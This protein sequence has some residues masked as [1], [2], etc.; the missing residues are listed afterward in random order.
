MSTN[1]SYISNEGFIRL[2]KVYSLLNKEGLISKSNLKSINNENFATFFGITEE[3]NYPLWG[4]CL[5]KRNIMDGFDQLNRKKDI[6]LQDV[7]E[8]CHLEN[9]KGDFNAIFKDCAREIEQ[10]LNKRNHWYLKIS[11]DRL[12]FLDKLFLIIETLSD[13]KDDEEKV[14][15]FSKLVK[16]L[17]D[18]QAYGIWSGHDW[19]QTSINHVLKKVCDD[20]SLATVSLV[21][22]LKTQMSSINLENLN[23][24]LL[25]LIGTFKSV[26]NNSIL[27]K[28]N[29]GNLLCG[30]IENLR[31][32]RK[33]FNIIRLFKRVVEERNKKVIFFRLELRNY[34]D[35]NVESIYFDTE[36][37]PIKNVKDSQVILDEQNKYIDYISALVVNYFK[38]LMWFLN[39]AQ[40]LK[41]IS[42]YAFDKAIQG[43]VNNDFIEENLVRKK[44][45]S[46]LQLK[47]PKISMNPFGSC[48]SLDS[49][50]DDSKS[51][52]K[53]SSLSL[54]PSLSS[55]SSNKSLSVRLLQIEA[56]SSP[57]P[58][59]PPKTK[60][61][62]KSESC[63]KKF[64][65]L[66]ESFNKDCHEKEQM[67]EVKLENTSITKAVANPKLEEINEELCT[68]AICYS[69]FYNNEFN[70]DFKNELEKVNLEKIEDFSHW[71]KDLSYFKNITLNQSIYIGNQNKTDINILNTSIKD[72]LKEI[73]LFKESLKKTN[74]KAIARFHF[75]PL[76][77][78]SEN[79]IL[80]FS[81]TKNCYR[82]MNDEGA[83]KYIWN[84]LC[85]SV[86][87]KADIKEMIYKL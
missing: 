32:N 84:A 40:Y 33:N 26:L 7:I 47:S 48:E 2:E 66:K 52:L 57:E 43:K 38:S 34:H 85:D 77:D 23:E 74:S 54:S 63:L 86:A 67:N 19:G 4:F 56:N 29:K 83:I 18:I 81:W 5:Y 15:L 20:L 45:N 12:L 71:S 30:K 61:T 16:A 65:N 36:L 11:K 21:V 50:Q 46:L 79:K 41:N 8:K 14:I 6:L 1:L 58:K 62:K 82:E 27:P 87:L 37:I 42:D 55:I 64:K 39:H 78:D 17:Y 68:E 22:K 25:H 69:D 75:I 76:K 51:L 49:I 44:S 73:E 72:L 24:K 80:Y 3:L 10:Y 31:N 59:T 70:S 60:G 28:N 35:K 53:S 13:F 9:T